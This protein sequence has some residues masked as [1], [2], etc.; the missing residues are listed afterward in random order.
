MCVFGVSVLC[1]DL[2]A[3][4]TVLFMVVFASFARLFVGSRYRLRR[5]G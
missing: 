2:C 3:V 5:F 1:S 4:V